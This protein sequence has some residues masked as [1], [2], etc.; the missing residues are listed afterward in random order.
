MTPFPRQGGGASRRELAR[1]ARRSEA[2]LSV[3][4]V[5]A[6]CQRCIRR[7]NFGGRLVVRRVVAVAALRL[8]RACE[9][10]DRLGLADR[11]GP[12]VLLEEQDLDRR[13]GQPPTHQRAD[14]TGRASHGDRRLVPLPCASR[15]DRWTIH[16]VKTG[17]G[18]KLPNHD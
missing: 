14:L 15:S 10:D 12:V 4:L 13:P 1:E 16:T 18:S 8:H 3:A 9:V 7:A 5:I 17:L 11:V 6:K 2:A